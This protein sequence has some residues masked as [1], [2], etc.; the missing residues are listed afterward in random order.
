MKSAEKEQVMNRFKQG[1]VRVLVSTTV[2]EVGVDVPNATIM[3]IE[4]AERFGLPQLHQLRGRVGRGDKPSYCFLMASYP[5]S[6]EA[7]KRL[8]TMVET[9]DGFK[10]A[11][12]DLQLR[13]PGEFFGTR[14]HGLPKLRIADIV[15]DTELL[16]KAREEAFSVVRQKEKFAKHVPTQLRSHFFKHYHEKFEFARV[17]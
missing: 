12:V 2:I 13:G 14:Q 6:N 10:I 16:M 1:T 5:I 8:N 4:H 17:G 9:T 7:R 3:V 11:E 15:R